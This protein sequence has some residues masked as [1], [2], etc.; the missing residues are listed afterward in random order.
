MYL[1]RSLGLYIWK[2]PR[3]VGN[4][5]DFQNFIKACQI[6]KLEAKYREFSQN[7]C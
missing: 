3:Q 2:R 6:A 5:Q 4:I 7:A 1:L